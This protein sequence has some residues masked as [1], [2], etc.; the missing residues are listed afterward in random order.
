MNVTYKQER[1]LSKIFDEL[2]SDLENLDDNIRIFIV[3]KLNSIIS[4]EKRIFSL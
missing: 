1:I 2:F 3:N 4:E